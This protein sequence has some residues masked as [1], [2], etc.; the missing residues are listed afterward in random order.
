MSIAQIGGHQ[1]PQIIYG[2]N[3]SGGAV[4]YGDLLQYDVVD[5]GGDGYEFVTP[6][7]NNAKP[8]SLF[9]RCGVV[10]LADGPM[11]SKVTFADG[12]DIALLVEGDV[13]KMSVDGS[14]TAVVK[15]DLLIRA[16]ASSRAVVAPNTIFDVAAMTSSAPTGTG[17]DANLVA[18]RNDVIAIR[19]NVESLVD[20]LK[21]VGIA[22]EASASATGIVDA[23][24]VKR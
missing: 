21:I 22:L 14:G 7:I 19:E 24:V 12:A 11:D 3:N 10:W 8:E 18:L 23:I 20:S 9:A 2:K 15:G 1:S 5:G 13:G 17:D 4:S 6:V 16:N